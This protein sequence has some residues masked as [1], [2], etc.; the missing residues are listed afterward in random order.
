MREEFKSLGKKTIRAGA[1]GR[2]L[3]ATIAAFPLTVAGEI[4]GMIGGT[5]KNEILFF[6]VKSIG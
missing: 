5:H 6:L 3:T 2:R 1:Q 4:G